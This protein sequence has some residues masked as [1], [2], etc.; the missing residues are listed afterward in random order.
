MA[1]SVAIALAMKLEKLFG[2]GNPGADGQSFLAI[3][4]PGWPM[5]ADDLEF[6]KPESTKA[7]ASPVEASQA[8]SSLARLVNLIPRTAGLCWD[9]SESL[10][11]DEYQRVLTDAVI[12]PREP[13]ENE[14][15]ALFEAR[16]VLFELKVPGSQEF[17]VPWTESEK[18]QAYHKYESIYRM[19]VDRS[20]SIELTAT[21]S[22]NERDR[23]ADTAA[24]ALRDW[25]AF[26]YKNEVEAAYETI[27]QVTG[28]N[29]L[30][31]WADWKDTFR[32]SKRA[33]ISSD[34]SYYD[35]YLYP[36]AFSDESHDANWMKLSM[37][38]GEVA[39]LT[40]GAGQTSNKAEE[41]SV[42]KLSLEVARV[43][44][45]RP[46]FTPSLLKSRSWE[47]GAAG[48]QPLS[49]GRS[50]PRGGMVAYATE[51][52]FARNIDIAF[53]ASPAKDTGGALLA[54][55]LKIDQ[56]SVV[57]NRVTSRGMQLIAFVCE[58]TPKSPNPPASGLISVRNKGAFVA[59]FALKYEL[60]GIPINYKSG[61]FPV[62]VTKDIPIH[63]DATKISMKIEIMT[64][65]KPVET[66]S[67]VVTNDFDEPVK[68]L[69]ELSGTTWN[70]KL[71]GPLYAG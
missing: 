46:W 12:L 13:T 62:L 71:A 19:Q 25:E 31:A 20:N 57:S 33:D 39:E 2:A 10:V 22:K 34:A 38:S 3:Q 55:P 64:F 18:L 70:P 37:D 30:L 63:R 24:R 17:V 58:R 50:S 49:D 26:G 53:A 6:I 29:P 14:K 45:I 9:P 43:K 1:S 68:Q 35:T 28:N 11:W 51:A 60:N 21:D 47:W 48:M 54:G 5:S 56:A 15:H 8:R 32:R 67:T 69:Y 36:E 65:P 41:V 40:A 42:E 59:R 52:I 23:A 27:D 44:I 66:W 4:T 61:N 16:K 7:K